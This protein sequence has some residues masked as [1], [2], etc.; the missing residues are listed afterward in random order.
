MQRL[1]RITVTS[2][3]SI[4]TVY[5][6]KGRYYKSVKRPLFGLSFC[7]EGQITYYHNGKKIVSDKEHAII[8]PKG[9]TYTLF[10]NKTGEFPLINF[11]CNAGFNPKSFIKIKLNTP[12]SYLKDFEKLK[13]LSLFSHNHLEM[14]TVF[15]KILNRLYSETQ[16]SG[17][18]LN[19]IISYIEKHYGNSE[20]S[21][22]VLASQLNISEVYMRR[23]FKEQFGT[24]PKQYIL[25]LRIQKAKQVLSQSNKTVTE[26]SKECGFTSIHHFCRAFK[27]YCGQTPSDYRNNHRKT[28]L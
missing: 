15:Y 5:S 12:E 1:N 23:L 25:E 18:S 21:N 9:E 11:R 24:S 10:G 3:D 17:N 16:Q 27:G 14:M 2:I 8:L 19:P 4:A 20:L 7:K 26:I 28:I 13:E 22:T 6:K